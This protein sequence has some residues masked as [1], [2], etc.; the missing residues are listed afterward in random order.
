LWMRL[1]FL[2][3]TKKIIASDHVISHHLHLTQ[4]LSSTQSQSCTFAVDSYHSALMCDVHM[5]N[6]KAKAAYLSINRKLLRLNHVL[7]L[8]C[9]TSQVLLHH[10]STSMR[11]IQHLRSIDLIQTLQLQERYWLVRHTQ[12]QLESHP[13]AFNQST[14]SSPFIIYRLS[15]TEQLLSFLPFHVTQTSTFMLELLQMRSMWLLVLRVMML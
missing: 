10:S 8:C 9:L 15:T 12:K 3:T 7:C 4:L 1:L 14:D 2:Q 13:N 11:T 6:R 5:C